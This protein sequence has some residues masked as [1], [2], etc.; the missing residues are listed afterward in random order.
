MLL[1]TLSLAFSA[2]GAVFAA[3][4]QDLPDFSQLINRD[5]PQGTGTNNGFFYSCWSDGNSFSYNNQ[6][7]GRYTVNWSQGSGNLVV[8]KGWNPGGP[9]NVVYNGTWSCP[10]NG[11]LS[12]YGWTTNP[13]VEYYIVETYGSYNPSSA[14]SKKGSV[15]SDGSTYDILQTTRTNQPSIKGTA[16]FQQYWSVRQSKRVGGTVTVGNHFDAWSKLGMKLGS[17][18]YMIMATEGY[19]ST[20]S[21]DI[22]VSEK[23]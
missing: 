2:I 16:T 7:G 11:Y 1:S 3:P 20:G 14:A 19:H 6:A 8:G 15:T 18:D 21:A 17:H 22:T 4:S 23:K 9:K 13:L 12:L 5:T 10:G